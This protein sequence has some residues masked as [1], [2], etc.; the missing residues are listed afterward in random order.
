MFLTRDIRFGRFALGV[1]GVEVLVEAIFM[2][3]PCVEGA[4]N[5]PERLG[6]PAW[7]HDDDL[8]F[9]GFR[10]PKNAGPFQCVPVITF[11]TAVRDR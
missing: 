3:L 4:P 11:V 2:R 9:A 5:A 10:S 6:I 7:T 1:K 8:P